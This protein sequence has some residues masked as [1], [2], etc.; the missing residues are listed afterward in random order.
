MGL[1]LAFNGLDRSP[2]GGPS[3]PS[4]YYFRASKSFEN[5]VS[6]ANDQE[7]WKAA[8]KAAKKAVWRDKGEPP[9][10][11]DSF[12]MCLDH[13]TRGALRKCQASE[14]IHY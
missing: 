1:P 7:R 14:S 8:S 6:L 11:L 5:L 2:S 10:P 9:V 12:T 13:A 3:T 4:V